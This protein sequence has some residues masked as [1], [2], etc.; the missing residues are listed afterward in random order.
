MPTLVD[1][2]DEIIAMIMSNLQFIVLTKVLM[3][4][5]HLYGYRNYALS[6]NETV[7][8]F[9]YYNLNM[10]FMTV[11]FYSDI[12]YT[13]EMVYVIQPLKE[14]STR[15]II[16]NTYRLLAF[17]NNYN[18]N[19]ENVVGW[20][21]LNLEYYYQLQNKL[22]HPEYYSNPANTAICEFLFNE[23]IH[24]YNWSYTNIDMFDIYQIIFCVRF[25][26][27]KLLVKIIEEM[28]IDAPT[29]RDTFVLICMNL[30][31]FFTSLHAETSYNKNLKAAIVAV[32][33]KFIYSTPIEY[34]GNMMQYSVIMQSDALGKQV[35]ELKY[36]P[37]YF[38]KLVQTQM[39]NTK[40]KMIECAD[41]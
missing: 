40:N 7:Q 36:A 37:K 20:N 32:L 11:L 17:D 34:I 25:K 15:A 3:T 26:N 28:H 35:D 29:D 16:Y 41:D 10:C 31:E 14:A 23:F 13:D 21:A 22:I 24:M 19:I 4:C 6:E 30:I 5:K 9:Q 8:A 2:H 33:Y 18:E 39:N 1:M 38:K 12:K 27:F